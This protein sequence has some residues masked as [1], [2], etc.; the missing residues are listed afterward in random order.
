MW[1]DVMRY[2]VMRDMVGW[3]VMWFGMV[4]Y[5]GMSDVA[6][7]GEMWCGV[8]WKNFTWLDKVGW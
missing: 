8:V 6:W 7:Y 4:W 2:D 5:D 3:D 1:R